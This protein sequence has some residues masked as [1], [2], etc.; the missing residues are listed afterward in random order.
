MVPGGSRGFGF[1][2][3]GG[4]FEFEEDGGWLSVVFEGLGV[5]SGGFRGVWGGC[6][7]GLRVVVGADL[8]F[9]GGGWGWRVVAIGCDTRSTFSG[10]RGDKKYET[11]CMTKCVDPGDVIE[12]DC[13]G[14]G[15]C[16]ASSVMIQSLK[17]DIVADVSLDFQG[18]LTF[19]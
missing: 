1:E 16:Q 19:L 4:W 14:V 9:D 10:V 7:W 5:V 12:G 3:D 17:S 6:Q 11:G 2:E 15:C 18:I 13:N 8:R